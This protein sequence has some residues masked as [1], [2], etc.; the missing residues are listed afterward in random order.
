MHIL[1]A[2]LLDDLTQHDESH[3]AV[4]EFLPRFRIGFQRHDVGDGLVRRAA[5]I[6]DRIVSDQAADVSQQMSNGDLVFAI[7][8]EV[9]QIRRDRRIHINLPLLNQHHHAGGRGD[10]FGQR[11]EI[12]HGVD[13]HRNLLRHRLTKAISLPECNS[14]STS[15]NDHRPRHFAL[16]E[17]FV[18]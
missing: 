5:V 11:G 10:R 18:D 3:V 15:N 4:G 9:R 6:F 13:C 17:P 8:R 2:D 14:A 16:T 1:S 12:E 7:G